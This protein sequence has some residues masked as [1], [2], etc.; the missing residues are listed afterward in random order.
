MTGAAFAASRRGKS[1]PEQ[2]QAGAGEDD[3][4][5]SDIDAEERR[6]QPRQIAGPHQQV[7]HQ[8]E[9]GAG[10]IRAA[11]TAVPGTRI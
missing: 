11:A 8:Q 5:E 10:R 7:F 1:R 2:I 4:A 3:Q 6:L 9:D